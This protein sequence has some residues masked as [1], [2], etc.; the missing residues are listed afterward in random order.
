MKKFKTINSNFAEEVFIYTPFS[1]KIKDGN[2][3]ILTECKNYKGALIIPSKIDN[4]TVTSIGDEAF[5]RCES[6]SS[7]TIPDSVTSIGE[8]A[9][10]YCDSLSSITIPDSVASIGESA[11][12]ECDSLLIQ[13]N[14]GSYAE[15]YC[16]NN[17]LEF[18]T[19]PNWLMTE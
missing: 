3:I 19:T 12:D 6:L 18:C 2:E 14:S 9:F 17:N 16:K 10:A 11:F 4:K 13:C 8:G 5:Y 7:I 15:K 1:F